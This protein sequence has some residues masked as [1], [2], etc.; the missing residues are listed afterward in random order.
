MANVDDMAG[1]KFASLHLLVT[2]RTEKEIEDS[3]S[4]LLKD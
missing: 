2:S 1:W 4:D 3:L